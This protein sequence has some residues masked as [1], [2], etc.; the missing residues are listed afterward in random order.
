MKESVDRWQREQGMVDDIT[1][2]IA[3]LNVG[4]ADPNKKPD[5]SATR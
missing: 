5:S 3:F 2:V 1:I 4:G